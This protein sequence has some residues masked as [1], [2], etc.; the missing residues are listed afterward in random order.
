MK[1]VIAIALFGLFLLGCKQTPKAT[2]KPYVATNEDTIALKE[3]LYTKLRLLNSTGTNT[4]T[5]VGIKILD[6]VRNSEAISVYQNM[7][8][9]T[10]VDELNAFT[11]KE[12][13]DANI[14]ETI[15]WGRID[16]RIREL[17][18]RPSDSVAYF[19]IRFVTSKQHE[20]YCIEEK[21]SGF[22]K[23]VS[24]D[25]FES[26]KPK[27]EAPIKFYEAIILRFDASE[28]FLF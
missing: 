9:I 10:A 12:L 1:R 23:I 7:F 2:Y 18:K 5:I 24:I 19:I 14:K 4:E 11:T 28:K 6:V 27:Y 20:A 25:E 17:K 21:V 13:K 16:D 8:G 26:I 3:N 15:Y 22:T